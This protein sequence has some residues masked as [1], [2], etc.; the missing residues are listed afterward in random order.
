MCPASFPPLFFIL[1][2][3]FRLQELD[4]YLQPQEALWSDFEVCFH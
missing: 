2:T 3:L 1:I 4:M